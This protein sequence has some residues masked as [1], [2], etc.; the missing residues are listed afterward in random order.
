MRGVFDVDDL[1]A[2]CQE[3]VDGDDPRRAIHEVLDRTLAR[4]GEIAAALDPQEGGLE[5]L[6][7]APDLT[8]LHVVW[9]PGMEL[10]PHDHRMWAAIGIYTGQEDNTF[11][12]RPEPQA[13][14]LTES[15]GKRL[16]AG[17]SVVLGTETI[18]SVANPLR[19]LT[20]AIHVYG[21]DFVR[22]E[23]SQWGPGPREERPYDLEEARRQFT[24]A[25]AA[26]QAQRE[27]SGGA[28]PGGIGDP[29]DEA[30]G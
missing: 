7:N 11:Y 29:A 1:I 20:G 10:Y 21:G 19:Q 23:R 15:G 5:L 22:Q 16:A 3:A 8:V 30:A 24:E 17:E 2:R 12:R 14:T 26:W 28:L 6:H 18:H 25:N 9:A 13:R 4:P 27:G